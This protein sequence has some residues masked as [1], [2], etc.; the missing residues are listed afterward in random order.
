MY[1]DKSKTRL[2]NKKTRGTSVPR[3]VSYPSK[4]RARF[5]VVSCACLPTTWLVPFSLNPPFV[6]LFRYQPSVLQ[7]TSC[8]CLRIAY[9]ADFSAAEHQ[10]VELLIHFIDLLPLRFYGPQA[11]PLASGTLRDRLGYLHLWWLPQPYRILCWHA[12]GWSL[13]L[14]AAVVVI[15]LVRCHRTEISVGHI[16]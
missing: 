15:M 3:R 11:P 4:S 16:L 7:R 10:R 9:T 2:T 14:L 6:G 5:A 8:C 13:L 1:P 12:A